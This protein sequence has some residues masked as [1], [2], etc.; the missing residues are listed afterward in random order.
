MLK[1]TFPRLLIHISLLSL[2]LILQSCKW[3]LSNNSSVLNQHPEKHDSTE[4]FLS[5]PDIGRDVWQKPD[6]VIRQLGDLT[7]KTIADIGAGTGYFSFRLVAK[8]EKVIAIE[9]DTSAIRSIEESKLKLPEPFR[10]KLETRLANEHDPM[11]R[12]NEVDIIVIINTIAYIKNIPAYLETLKKGLKKGGT[13]MIVD[14]KMKKLPIDAPP[15]SER[16]YLD[17]LETMLEKAGYTEVKTN[18]T[19]LDYQY[20]ITAK[21]EY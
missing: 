7:G 16:I 20:I 21:Y 13:L 6:L 9:I 18:D 10:P 3:E 5:N 14:Y 15:K 2:I 12:D 17:V 1:C 4:H 19:S 8:A 11:L